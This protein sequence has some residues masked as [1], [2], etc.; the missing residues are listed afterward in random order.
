MRCLIVDDELPA[1]K[2]LKF[3]L[4]EFKSIKV[5]GEAAHGLEAMELSKRLKPDLIFLD[6]QMPKVSG[7]E[8]ADEIIKAENAPLIIFVTAFEQFAVEAFE[9]NA[10]DYLLKPV[11]KQRLE[12]SIKR[13]SN[14]LHEAKTKQYAQKIDNLINTFNKNKRSRVS[15]ISINNNGRLI[16]I[17]PS[18]IIYL[19]VD[20]RN[21]R[22][23]SVKGTFESNN[24]LSQFEE[25]LD[26]QNFFRTHKSFLI[27]L[28]FIEEIVP[29]FNS[30]YLV[31]L[32]GIE[33]KIP[34]SR[35]RIKDFRAVMNIS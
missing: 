17:D 28:D 31:E 30:T 23:V 11:S 4:E 34:V 29:W 2:E 3:L 24:T 27:N 19:T 22:I 1:R 15:K 26:H 5:I 25:K 12:K 21:T 6:I 20:Q 18:E 10:I 35:S 16:P 14:Q 7:I 13:A 9:I 33:E 32:K 8:V